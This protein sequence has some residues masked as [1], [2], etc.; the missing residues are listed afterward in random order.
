[1]V[2]RPW[3]GRATYAAPVDEVAASVND[4]HDVLH[5]EKVSSVLAFCV[6]V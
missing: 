1:M 3:L 6:I 2:A 4:Q 5:H